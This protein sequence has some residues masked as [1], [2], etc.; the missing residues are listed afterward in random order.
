[1][2]YWLIVAILAYL[3]FAL[4]SL[5]DKLVLAG[6]P[7]PNSYTFYIGCFGLVVLAIVPFIKMSF[8]T[9][10]GL[11]WIILDAVV[12]VLGLY[13]MFVALEKFEVSKVM[14]TIGATQ[15]IFIFILTW[16]FFGPQALSLTAIVAFMILI[17]GGVIMFTGEG[18]KNSGAYFG[19]TILSSLMFALDYIFVKLVFINE[20]FW[21]GIVWM[22]IFI[23]LIASVLLIK[24]SSRKEIFEKKMVTNKKTQKFF[25]LAQVFGGVG[26][27][28]QSFSIFLVPTAFLAIAN[29]L[30]GIQYVFLFLIALFVSFFFPLV[31]KEKLS[32][33]I[34]VR[35]TVSIIL[36]VIGLALLI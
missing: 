24:K 35:K 34:I 12:R 19:L 30:R 32:K 22:G 3:C 15:P 10:I 11:T 21:L 36:I 8:P 5:Y 18:A 26:S 17:I 1:M 9:S 20:N 28:L 27:F 33:K 23:F 25:V 16:L 13:I 6:K 7:K 2:V 29:S 4:G 31:L 14:A